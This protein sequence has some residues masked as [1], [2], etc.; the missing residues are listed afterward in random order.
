MSA[1]VPPAGGDS[2]SGRNSIKRLRYI[3]ALELLETSRQVL[4]Q[5][6]LDGFRDSKPVGQA[7]W[8]ASILPRRRLFKWVGARPPGAKFRFRPISTVVPPRLRPVS[9]PLSCGRSPDRA[10]QWTEGAQIPG[11]AA[12]MAYGEVRR[13][14]RIRP[15]SRSLPSAWW[16]RFE[17]YPGFRGGRA[18]K[19]NDGLGGPSYENAGVHT[20]KR[21]NH[22]PRLILARETEFVSFR[23]P[24]VDMPCIGLVSSPAK[25]PRRS[26]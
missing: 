12:G 10:T 14:L 22:L 23:I 6:G 21:A 15:L 26:R 11:R 2:G 9:C 20:Q 4:G 18:A 25:R 3:D 16:F 13:P 24:V 1:D 17:V 19:K 7:G 8:P 5:L